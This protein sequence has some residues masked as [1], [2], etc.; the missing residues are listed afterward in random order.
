MPLFSQESKEVLL[1]H[2]Y[3]KSYKWSDDISKGIES[4]FK[5]Y[6]SINLTTIYMDTKRVSSPQYYEKLL[7]LYQE[8]FKNR[9]FD[10]ILVSDN[11]ALEFI[12][13]HHN[14]LFAHTPVLFCGINNFDAS[15]IDNLPLVSG[16]VEQVDI[17]KNFQLIKMLHPNL[18]K[19]IIVNDYSTTGL[20]MKQALMPYIEKYKSFFEIIYLDDIR[21]NE[22]KKTLSE[23]KKEETVLL[24]VL[25]FKDKTG[26]FFTYKQSL[27]DIK[28]ITQIPRII[29][30]SSY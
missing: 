28:S 27:N 24:F 16:V 11:N 25:L 30:L 4:F 12:N 1:I 29:N 5:R 23:Q 22:I 9:T 19:L 15:L 13:T 7:S 2:S 8:Q 20:Q 6:K 21:M 10:L 14:K 18:K 3:D 17:E 26:Q